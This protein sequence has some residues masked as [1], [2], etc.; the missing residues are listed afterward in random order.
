MESK[1]EFWDDLNRL[2]KYLR[3]DENKRVCEPYLLE[4]QRFSE[5]AMQYKDTC[6]GL[7]TTLQAKVSNEKYSVGGESLHRGYYCPS[8]ILDIVSGNC[9]RGKLLKRLTIK[10]KPTYKYGFD[11]DKLIVI[12]S[13]HTDKNEIIVR[14]DKLEIG[15][16]FSKEFGIQTISECTHINGQIA[17]YTV[18]LY[19][20][21]ENRVVDY[22]KEDYQYSSE[23]LSVVD[24]FSFLNSK[25]APILQHQQ[26]HFLHD[27]EGYLSKYTVINYEG[28]FVKPS[29]WDNHTFDI[30]IKRKI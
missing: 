23:G 12:N 10:S 13:I 9:N 20:P 14:K 8:P 26:Y 11:N 24:I 17:S 18:C 19:D 21:F 29:V 28:E 4:C 27:N 3:S 6:E 30:S 16:V 5:I 7:Y 1:F 2:E 25:N 15:I 22:K